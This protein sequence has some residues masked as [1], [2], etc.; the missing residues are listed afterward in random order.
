MKDNNNPFDKQ[1]KKGEPQDA[2]YSDDLSRAAVGRLFDDDD[3]SPAPPPKPSFSRPK[4]AAPTYETAP[5][6][7]SFVSG[8]ERNVPRPPVDDDGDDDEEVVV[9]HTKR[10]PIIEE[11][12]KRETSRDIDRFRPPPP[13]PPKRNSWDEEDDEGVDT[14]WAR[15]NEEDDDIGDN[16]I[17]N[18]DIEESV[19]EVPPE[20]HRRRERNTTRMLGDSQP[21]ENNSYNTSRRPRLERLDYQERNQESSDRPVI[22]ERPTRTEQRELPLRLDRPER[23]D[24][25]NPPP[26]PAVRVNVPTER[27]PYDTAPRHGRSRDRTNETSTRSNYDT[28]PRLRHD[29]EAPVR[30]KYDTSPRPNMS[31]RDELQKLPNPTEDDLNAFR[32]RYQTGELFSPPRNTGRPQRQQRQERPERGDGHE[33]PERQER[34]G[35]GRAERPE[36]ADARP[37]M[38]LAE[39]GETD[40]VS[41]IK[42]IFAVAACVVLVIIFIL[43]FSLVSARGRYRDASA[44]LDQ[45]RIDLANAEQNA[46]IHH[47][48]YVLG[49]EALQQEYDELYARLCDDCRNPQQATDPSTDDGEQRAGVN[50]GGPTDLAPP[51]PALPT[52]HTVVTNDTLNDIARRYFGNANRETLDH[53]MRDNQIRNQ[54]NIQLGAVLQ[55]NPMP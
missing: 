45:A 6:K 22:H 15:P 31:R 34:Q 9:T 23:Q 16:A 53:I 55:I 33:R 3:D 52:T 51:P 12:P 8:F 39:R 47:R 43:T 26:R 49:L 1:G 19:E 37:R 4:P 13:S 41:P 17:D 11:L 20:R 32:N 50:P 38:R 27:S 30:S 48:P 2:H 24:R 54:N 46:V 44:A 42:M 10:R 36:R 7:S 35:G 40:A 14:Q 21:R 18:T 25:G 28:S 29:L 5:V